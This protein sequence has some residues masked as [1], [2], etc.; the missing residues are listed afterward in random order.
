MKRLRSFETGDRCEQKY[1]IAELVG[2]CSSNLRVRRVLVCAPSN[3]A[4]DEIVKRLTADPETGGGIFDGNGQRF[5]PAV[6]DLCY[7]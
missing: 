4:I 5:S 2:K 1:G 7:E 6:G 3:A